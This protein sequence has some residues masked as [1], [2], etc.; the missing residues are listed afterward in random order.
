[1][2]SV[3]QHYGWLFGFFYALYQISDEGIHL[4]AFI[5]IVLVLPFGFLFIFSRY[6]CI[7][8]LKYLSRRMGSVTF[9]GNNMHKISFFA[10]LHNLHNLIS[11]NVSIPQFVGVKD[12]LFMYSTE[13]K[14]SK[15]DSGIPRFCYRKELCDYDVH[16]FL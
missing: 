12:T 2:V 6:L 10:F 1:M 5:Q 9:Y 7:R 3:Y 15:P 4:L 11:E 16:W 13:V 14:V 8:T